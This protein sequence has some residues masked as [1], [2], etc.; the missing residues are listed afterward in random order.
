[1]GGASESGNW[2]ADYK[3]L[4]GHLGLMFQINGETHYG[5]AGLTVTSFIHTVKTS[6]LCTPECQRR[7]RGKGAALCRS[8]GTAPGMVILGWKSRARKVWSRTFCGNP[9]IAPELPE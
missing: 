8:I 7:R 3:G 4:H 6:S 9:K 5:W 2:I 1:M